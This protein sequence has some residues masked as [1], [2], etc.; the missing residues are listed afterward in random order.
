MDQFHTRGTKATLDLARRA[1]IASGMRLLDAGGGLGGPA[2]TLAGEFG[3][4]V[5]VLD[6]T[7][8]LVRADETLISRTSLGGERLLFGGGTLP[9]CPTRAPASTWCGRST[10][11]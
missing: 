5:D 11:R 3:C 10:A 8:K 7:E 4:A 9:R 1:G 2:R 6:L